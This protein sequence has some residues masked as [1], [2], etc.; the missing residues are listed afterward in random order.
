MKLHPFQANGFECQPAPPYTSEEITAR[1]L[2]NMS[3]M[4]YLDDEPL[5]K[6]VEYFGVGAKSGG[7]ESSKILDFG[8]GFAG[9]ARVLAGTHQPEPNQGYTMLF[10]QK[11]LLEFFV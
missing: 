1:D 6:A 10:E 5:S 3:C 8:S 7:G 11:T 4:H 9:D 2:Y